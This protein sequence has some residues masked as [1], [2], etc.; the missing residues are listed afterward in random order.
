MQENKIMKTQTKIIMKEMWKKQ[1][2]NK[3]EKEDMR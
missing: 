1:K 2:L 3:K